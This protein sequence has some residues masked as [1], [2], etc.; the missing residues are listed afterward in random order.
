VHVEADVIDIA[1]YQNRLL[2]FNSFSFQAAED[3]LYFILAS[4]EQNNCTL[5]S[6]EIILAGE[7]ETGSALYNTLKKYVP[8]IKFAVADKSIVRK[9]D[10][11]KL[12]DHFYFIIYTCA[13]YKRHIPG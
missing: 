6:T 1:L 11:A 3:F 8:K 7:I 9:N 4:L 2:F 10:F 13:H 5:E 12:P